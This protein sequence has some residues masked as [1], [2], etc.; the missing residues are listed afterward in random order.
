MKPSVSYRDYFIQ[1]ESF[2][3]EQNGTW[4]PQYIWKRLAAGGTEEASTF[5][6]DQYQFHIAFP[7][8]VEADEYAL[9]RAKHW[10]DGR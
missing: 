6:T 5:P 2:Q 4:I 9:D 7:T 10:I 3:R 8:E 1:A